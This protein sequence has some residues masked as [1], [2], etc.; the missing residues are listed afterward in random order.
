MISE[1]HTLA[2]ASEPF[3]YKEKKSKFWGYA[4]PIDQ[5]N[6]VKLFLEELKSMHPNAN[7]FCYAWSIGVHPVISRQNDDGEPNNTAGAP[8]YG[9]IQS[10]NLSNTA[11][12]VVRIFGGVKLGPGGLISAYKTAAQGALEAASIVKK[13]IKKNYELSCAYSKLHLLMRLIKQYN[14]TIISQDLSN[15]CFVKAQIAL[16]TA[17]EFEK[18]INEFRYIRWDQSH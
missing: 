2:K 1:F 15:Q 4:I 12:V 8:I 7:H 14:A 18:T 17:A 5:E 13:T 11:V 9:Q 6:D 16:E 3:L 10:F